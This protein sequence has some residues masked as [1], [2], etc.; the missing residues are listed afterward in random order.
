VALVAAG[1]ALLVY[2]PSL[3]GGFLY[4]DQH[5]IVG[6]PY[7][8]DLGE[9]GVILRHDPA[10]PL[11]S[12]T[13]ALNY[14]LGGLTA[15]PYHLVNVLLHAGNAAL[16]AS[17]FLWMARR[18]NRPQGEGAALLAACLFAASPMAA[19]T[20]AYASSRSTALA[21]FFG[22]A[23]LRLG[24]GALAGSSRLLIPALVCNVLALASKE[25]AAALPLLLL[26]LDFFFVAEQRGSDLWTRRSRHLWFVVLPLLGLAGRR[27]ATGG[28]LPAPALDPARFLA[29]QLAAFPLYFLRAL[30]PLDPAFYRNHPA[31]PWPPNI[32][33]MA[34]GLVA[35]AFV[36]GAVAWRRR[37]PEWSLAVFWL[38]AGLLP[39]SSIVALKEM[40]VD[41]RAY[42]GAAGVHFA[43]GLLLWRRG[44]ARLCAGLI[45]LLG[46]RAMHYE[47]VL[48]SPV[49]SWQDAVR[50]APRSGEAWRALGE[51][52]AAQRDPRAEE[53][54]VTSVNLNP[55]DARCWTNLGAYYAEQGRLADAEKAMRAAARVAPQDARIRDN[56][57]M[58]LQALGREAEA[59]GEFEAAVAGQPPLAQPRLNLAAL[60]IRHG[61]V[62][63][64]RD[65]VEDAARYV[66]DAQEGEDVGR[67]QDQLRRAPP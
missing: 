64:A 16:L 21:T 19:E 37:R 13:W 51:A 57:G 1:V 18:W 26:L 61:Q 11:L 15:W 32:A 33:T 28:W 29:T 3:G 8:R 35:L 66:Q 22:L 53:A 43:L 59:L 30:V 60:L 56:L 10:R 14:A 45:L 31:S 36:A 17:L 63:R 58:I 7:I 62:G 39:S 24:A 55:R 25:E 42:L 12:L 44:R 2:L 38:A 34:G 47:W 27:L 6:N 9:W 5:V 48:A 20:V 4:D 40:V 49:R 46:A 23:T 67:L 50:R 52:Y 41:H 65:L 54:L